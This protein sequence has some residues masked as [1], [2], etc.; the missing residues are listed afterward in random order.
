MASLP[1]VTAHTGCENTRPNSLESI[2][3]GISAGADTVE[4]DVRATRDLIPI[5]M[6][7]SELIYHGSTVRVEELSLDEIRGITATDAA[8]SAPVSTLDEAMRLVGSQDIM[9]NLDL[10]DDRCI[11]GV[12]ATIRRYSMSEKILLSGCE[13]NRAAILRALA[14]ELPVLL[15]AE[16][17]SDGLA[18]QRYGD[19]VDTTCLAATRTG[20]CGINVAFE[21]CRPELVDR[22]QRR[23]LPV[24]VWTVD[25]GRDMKNLVDMGVHSITTLHPR[26]LL[27]LLGRTVPA[28]TAGLP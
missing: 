24:S 10:K 2:L 23:Y 19:F 1:L 27:D 13:A 3:A 21:A 9:L 20:C 16:M 22:S 14:P 15:N 26:L 18:A 17:P 11:E 4:V 25:D 5:L 6:H 28:Q 8:I 7:D 12:V